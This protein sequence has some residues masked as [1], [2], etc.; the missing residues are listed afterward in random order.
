M[1]ITTTIP[2]YAFINQFPTI[3][4][5][6]SPNAKIALS[7][8][9]GGI[10]ILDK[11]AYQF[12]KSGFIYIK[13]LGD[14]LEKHFYN[15]NYD[16]RYFKQ[17]AVFNIHHGATGLFVKTMDV[18]FCRTYVSGEKLEPGVVRYM[19]LS[20]CREKRTLLGVAE[21]IPFVGTV[22]T[23]VLADVCYM[24]SGVFRKDTVT[25]YSFGT[26]D[27]FH[28]FDVSAGTVA[29]YVNVD[30]RCLIC[31]DVYLSG[32]RGNAM[33][34]ILD[35]GGSYPPT[36]LLFQNCFGGVE[37]FLCRG[38]CKLGHDSEREKASMGGR[39]FNAG[40]TS[41]LSYTV[42]TGGLTQELG[43]SLIDLLNCRSLMLV[44]GNDVIPV[45][46][47]S[48][49]VSLPNYRDKL[50]TAEFTFTYSVKNLTIYR[51]DPSKRIFDYTFDQSFN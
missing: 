28:S 4:I 50:A 9:L 24:Y 46:I 47:A 21:Y 38:V 40:Q 8:Y 20:R 49:N 27:T 16:V 36:V 29:G 5:T 31:W 2:E 10:L 51:Y 44:K 22:G 17:Q 37:S 1:D 19:P 11:E 18:Y 32:H 33:R 12:D 15:E 35:K 43:E 48:E 34:Y 42:N 13:Y 26:A 3:T 30:P 25:L 7:L 45:Q 41:L 14:T 6:G 23:M 39:T